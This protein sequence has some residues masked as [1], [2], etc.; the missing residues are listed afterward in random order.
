MAK[1]VAHHETKIKH[2][3]KGEAYENERR[4]NSEKACRQRNEK[5][6]NNYDWSRHNLNFEIVDGKII[7]LGSQK[8]SLYERYQRKL[9]S[10]DFKAYKDGA[11]NSQRTYA[12]LILSGSTE[13]MQKIAFGDQ[14][15]NYERNPKEWH[16]WNI[17]RMPAIEEWALDVYDFVC[18]RYGKDDVIGF[19]VHLDETE[20]H[21]HVNLV[22]TA[23]VN[24]RGRL[25]GYHKV[26]ADG[27]PVFHT[28]GKHIGEKKTISDKQ[29]EALS[30]KKKKE[31]RPNV[32][33][34]FR[35]VSYSAH[36]GDKIE[37]R[38]DKMSDL[39]TQFYHKV[40]KKWGFERGDVWAKLSEEE[41]LE[42]RRK[43]K[44]EAYRI[45]EAKKLAK[46]QQEQIE[47]NN[48]QIS[49][50]Q[51]D[52]VN[53]AIELT[54]TRGKIAEAKAELAK[55]SAVLFD[56]KELD[57]KGLAELT[58]GDDTFREMLQKAVIDI[59]NILARPK[60]SIFT[61]DK[62]WKKQQ[63]QAVRQVLTQL[64]DKLFADN[65]VNYAQRQA[66]KTL[67][68][69]AYKEAK[70]T[71]A[72]TIAEN[73]KLKEE[74]VELTVENRR[75]H[76]IF[77]QAADKIHNL[78]S[79]VSQQ[80]NEIENQKIAKNRDGKPMKWGD[81]PR[82]GQ[83]ITKDEQIVFLRQQSDELKIH[84]DDL[85]GSNEEGRKLIASLLTGDFAVA[86]KMLISLI[87]EAVR[88]FTKELKEDMERFLKVEKN[89][90]GRKSYIR[91][92]FTFVDFEITTNIDWKLSDEQKNARESLQKDANRIADGTWE[93]YHSL[94]DT[95][96]DIV[97]E[98]VRNSS[99]RRLTTSQQLVIMEL[100]GMASGD[101]DKAEILNTLKEQAGERMGNVVEAW[102][103]DAL[104]ELD[105][106]SKGVTVEQPND[107]KL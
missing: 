7:P 69:E 29:Y 48:S 49:Q 40:G 34:T 13:R 24:Q 27:N 28:K 84:I 60:D 94:L 57:D 64:Q 105:N 92:A 89:E 65:G 76:T 71:I 32:R 70:A 14:Q 16:N 31:Y 5:P 97:A 104:N 44:E 58:I 102:K 75:D 98:R 38:S 52:L 62:E 91:E 83:I 63:N 4:N 106:L 22:P 79:T 101:E 26:D 53:Q 67:M 96:A 20:P 74:N 61:S 50:Q 66:I 3:S 72:G 19:E 68:K 56:E 73:K 33:R 42:R 11:T 103:Q 12:S 82:K 10:L 35:A 6:Y 99:Q 100:L 36:F 78:E 17:K 45:K 30:Q 95:A 39:H 54:H 93:Q 41:K 23:I 47:K 107:V 86:V 51:K 55:W 37:E 80:K 46:K 1:G 43:T 21:V 87:K 8:V 88:E 90:D 15:V 2:M 77:Q 9:K 81:G 25:G 59:D 85:I 18:E